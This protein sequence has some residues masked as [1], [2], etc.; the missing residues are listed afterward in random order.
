[1]IKYSTIKNSGYIFDDIFGPD[2]TMLNQIPRKRGKFAN[3]NTDYL[4]SKVN[5]LCTLYRLHI[6]CDSIQ[7]KYVGTNVYDSQK[8]LVEISLALSKLKMVYT[9]RSKKIYLTPDDLFSN[10]TSFLTF[11]LP[12]AMTLSFL[13]YIIFQALPAKLQEVVQ[14]GGYIFSDISQLTTSHL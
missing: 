9:V 10:F 8:M 3:E 7:L 4:L 2:L 11:L 12:N 13:F 1:M 14:L 6:F 5:E